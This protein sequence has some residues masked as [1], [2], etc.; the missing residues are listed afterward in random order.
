MDNNSTIWESRYNKRQIVNKYP[1]D[2]VVSFM[3]SNYRENKK[4]IKVLDLGCG[5]G[6]NLAFLAREGYDYY[7]IDY[8][9][10][11][12]EIVKETFDY[13]SLPI[14]T[15]KLHIA[16]F[17][18]LPFEDDFFDVI[19]DRQSVGQNKYEVIENVVS[20]V[21]RTLKSGGKYF[22][23]NFSDRSIEMSYGTRIGKNQYKDFTQGRFKG[24]GERHF[25][26][27][28]EIF[29]LFKSFEILSL[30]TREKKSFYEPELGA[31]EIIVIAK[32]V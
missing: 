24:I 9:P 16:S 27:I 21:K 2:D 8:S 15:H 28:D 12:I 7:A 20:E 1:Y 5:T 32:K 11:A 3:L 31:E 17:E 19:I 13:F 6:N 10:S 4:S 23:I 25:F 14:E 22:G 30:D 26:N 18:K 29:E